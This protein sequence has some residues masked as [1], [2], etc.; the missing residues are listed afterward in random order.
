MGFG[1]LLQRIADKK[2]G[3]TGRIAWLVTKPARCGWVMTDSTVSLGHR[4]VPMLSAEKIVPKNLPIDAN[5][6][7]FIQY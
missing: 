3:R 2:K 5:L 1:V 6:G 7:K 4:L